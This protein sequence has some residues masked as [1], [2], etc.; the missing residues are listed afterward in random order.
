MCGESLDCP[1]YS[2]FIEE[3]LKPLM[4]EYEPQNIYNAD[5]TTL[6]YKSL[7]NRTMSFDNEEVHGSKLYQ[8][9][10][11]M[12]LLLC[13]NMNGS[14]KLNQVLIGKAACPTALKKHGGMA[15]KTS[16]QLLCVHSIWQQVFPPPHHM[17]IYLYIAQPVFDEFRHFFFTQIQNLS[18]SISYFSNFL[19][20]IMD[21]KKEPEDSK[22]E[23]IEVVDLTKQVQKDAGQTL[24]K[25]KAHVSLKLTIHWL[26][27]HVCLCLSFCKI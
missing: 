24:A 2:Q 13:T 26:H 9:K 16:C 4:E 27:L 6:F 25:I 11:C 15:G 5:E 14:E 1:D 23:I 8:S 21:I 18:S 20:F 10:D 19:F 22:C 3:V 7:S 12:S 17:L